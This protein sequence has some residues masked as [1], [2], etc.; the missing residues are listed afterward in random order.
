[1]KPFHFKKIE[2]ILNVECS[3]MCKSSIFSNHLF[4]KKYKV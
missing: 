1:M 4:N 3:I 2:K